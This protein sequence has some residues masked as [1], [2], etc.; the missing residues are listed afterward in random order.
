MYTPHPRVL[1][2]GAILFLLSAVFQLNTLGAVGMSMVMTSAVSTMVLYP[3]H[4]E[5]YADKPNIAVAL[6]RLWI[7]LVHHYTAP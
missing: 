6:K 2:L 3:R 7:K 4:P 5:V 1:A